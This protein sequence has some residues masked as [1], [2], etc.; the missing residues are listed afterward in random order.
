MF[1]VIFARNALILPIKIIFQ[2]FRSLL[3]DNLFKR[4]HFTLP[5]SFALFSPALNSFL[6]RIRPIPFSATNG[7][8]SRF[9]PCFKRM[10]KSEISL[11]IPAIPMI[12]A[13]S[14]TAYKSQS[15]VS[16]FTCS[17]PG[18]IILLKQGI[19]PFLVHPGIEHERGFDC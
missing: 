11:C 8:S 5:T 2:R 13:I 14:S 12:R 3:S 15:A 4:V 16:R 10:R 19:L 7:R 17:S 9:T 1:W 6:A 18:D